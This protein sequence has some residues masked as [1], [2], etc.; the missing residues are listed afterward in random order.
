MLAA[1]G[2]GQACGGL[3]GRLLGAG[4]ATRLPMVMRQ[5]SRTGAPET[6]VRSEAKQLIS[7]AGAGHRPFLSKLVE[8]RAAF[9]NDQDVAQ[10]FAGRF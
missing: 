2:A 7:L 4:V 9:V 5:L 3:L 6:E 1:T 10:H 8:L